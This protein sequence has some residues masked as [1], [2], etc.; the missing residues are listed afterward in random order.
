MSWFNRLKDGLSKTR[1]VISGDAAANWEMDWDDLEFALIGSDT[2]AKIAAEVVEE[3]RKER[4]RGTTFKEALE[5]A[6]MR[7]LEPDRTRQILRNV[8]FDLDVTRN[9]VAVKGKV[10]MIIQRIGCHRGT[11]R[12]P[13]GTLDSSH[14]GCQG[15]HLVLKVEFEGTILCSS[16]HSALLVVKITVLE[17]I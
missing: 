2:G 4:E 13:F 5:T 16:C 1:T 6:L 8:G 12:L 9:M 10:V 17:K 3:T 7:Q 15:C 11:S 14:I